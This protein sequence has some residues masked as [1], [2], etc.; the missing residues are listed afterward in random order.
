MSEP[1]SADKDNVVLIDD[2][3][4]QPLDKIDDTL[5][6]SFAKDI[7]EQCNRL[8]DLAKHL[9]TLQI[10][11][12]GIFAAILKLVAGENA[13]IKQNGQVIGAYIAWLLGLALTWASLIPAKHTIDRDSLT[14]IENYFTGSATRKLRWL[15]PASGLTFVGIMLAVWSIYVA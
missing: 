8:D 12:P 6:E 9:I 4:T 13:V 14:A 7:A 1:T 3:I 11:I 2:V 5:R 10:A 15:I